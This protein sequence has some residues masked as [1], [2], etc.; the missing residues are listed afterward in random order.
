MKALEKLYK[1]PK[2]PGS[3]QG[4]L[5]LYQHAKKTGLDVTQREVDAYLQAEPVYTFNRTA[6]HRF[7]RNRVIVEGFDS[8]W[9]VDLADMTDIAVH[10]DGHKYF[11]LVIDV[12]SRYVWIRPIKTKHASVIIRA[13]ESVLTEGRRPRVMRS[14]GGREFQNKQVK[15][16]L[17][18]RDIGLF[19]TYNETQANYAERAIKTVK[20]KLYRYLINKNTLRYIDILQDMANSYNRTKHTSLGRSPAEVNEENESEVRLEQYLRRRPSKKR[21]QHFR[22]DLGD[23]VRVSYRRQPFDR[24][25]GMR[26]SGEIF[27]VCKRRMREGIPVYGLK[28]WYGEDIKGSFYDQQLQKV[29]VSEGDAFKIEKVLKRRKRRGKSE[30]YVKWLHWPPKF[31]AWI[32]V[33][34]VTQL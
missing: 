5:K 29:T 18:D 24:E 25:Y 14:D 34:S 22:F 9:D 27:S 16:F 13:L 30:V 2:E 19:S 26:W 12:F 3:F 10:N 23:R 20:N 1:N 17:E 32:D 8:Q 28:D 4:P 21:K 31:N 15:Q 33:S 7:P 11:L 6:F